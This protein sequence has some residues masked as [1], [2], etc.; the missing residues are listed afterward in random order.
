MVSIHFSGG[1]DP[2]SSP[3]RGFSILPF[4]R[5]C[6]LP[7]LIFFVNGFSLSQE[8]KGY[9]YWIYQLKKLSDFKVVVIGRL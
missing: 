6:V 3:G 1:C 5:L 2:G 7:K 9:G 4:D 8:G